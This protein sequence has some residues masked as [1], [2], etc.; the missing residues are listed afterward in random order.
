MN[1]PEKISKDLFKKLKNK[2][3]KDT[4]QKYQ[5]VFTDHYRENRSTQEYTLREDASEEV[6]VK[7]DLS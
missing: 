7:I 6:R 1:V 4:F 3:N 5:H 2:L